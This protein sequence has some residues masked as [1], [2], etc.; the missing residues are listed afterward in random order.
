MKTT[1]ILTSLIPTLNAVR[2]GGAFNVV[3]SRQAAEMAERVRVAANDDRIVAEGLLAALKVLD[4]AGDFETQQAAMTG[5]VEKADA[6]LGAIHHGNVEKADRV[7]PA[8]RDLISRIAADVAS[9]QDVFRPDPAVLRRLRADASE[10]TVLVDAEIREGV[11][12]GDH[13]TIAAKIFD[14]ADRLSGCGYA[15]QERAG[16]AIASA[17]VLLAA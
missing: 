4:G 3:I 16:T 17:V 2:G 14:D 13:A 12:P 15:E 10:L 11:R 7:I 9:I 6:L 1:A 8:A 5:V